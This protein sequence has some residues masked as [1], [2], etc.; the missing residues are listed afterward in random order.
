MQCVNLLPDSSY[1]HFC[2][3]LMK[4]NFLS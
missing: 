1:L 2:S 4:R 3:H